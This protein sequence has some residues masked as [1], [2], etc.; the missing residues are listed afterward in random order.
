[1]KY[2]S[3]AGRVVSRNSMTLCTVQSSC[4]SGAFCVIGSAFA[5]KKKP[6]CTMR[7]RLFIGSSTESL[8]IAYAAQENL[9]RAAEVTVWNQGVFELS[10]YTLDSL[11]KA[12]EATDF[13]LF[14]FAPDDVV[15]M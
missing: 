15:K 8:K 4:P 11:V 10:N 9:E 12:L 5:T 13:G 6:E 7:P 14:V 1:M 3:R 2:W